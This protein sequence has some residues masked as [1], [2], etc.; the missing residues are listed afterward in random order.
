MTV[1]TLQRTLPPTSAAATP[2]GHEGGDPIGDRLGGLCRLGRRRA[3]GLALAV[4]AAHV[5]LAVAAQRVVPLQAEPAS[6]RPAWEARGTPVFL[7]G[8]QPAMG[9]SPEEAE[10]DAPPDARSAPF[11]PLSPAPAA[12]APSVAAGVTGAGAAGE[13]PLGPAERPVDLAGDQPMPPS[14]AIQVAAEVAAVTAAVVGGSMQTVDPPAQRVEPPVQ[15]A[16]AGDRQVA[17]PTPAVQGGPPQ[18]PEVPVYPTRIPAA[19]VLTYDLRR[20]L[21]SGTGE[22]SWRPEGDRY[23]ARLE[24]RVAGLTLLEWSSQGR[25][26][27]AGLAPDRYVERRRT[28]SRQA[29]N[30]Q[31][32]AGKVTYSGPAHEHPLVRGAQDRLSWMLQIAAIAQARPEAVARDATVS[33]WVSSARGD[34]DVWT[35]RSY[36]AQRLDLAGSAVQAV[37]LERLP[38]EPYDTRVEVWLE[39]TRGYLPV[40]ARLTSGRDDDV[41]DLVLRP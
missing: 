1:P 31:R 26:D 10:V 29:A 41:L 7:I 24:G 18:A 28:G 36:G 37:K 40:R 35:F 33:M 14:P 2:H 11:R 3:M 38:R 5:G 20:G 8:L 21:F 19:A 23:A 9:G 4:L 27:S 32:D 25:F 22:L 34:G 17:V 39:P 15:L 16:A 13:P 6:P 12:L 30:F